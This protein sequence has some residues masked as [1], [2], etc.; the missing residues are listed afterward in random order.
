MR[1]KMSINGKLVGGV[2]TIGIED[3]ASGTVFEQCPIADEA[4]LDRA[5]A[6]AKA[7]FPAWASRTYADRGVS[8]NQFA[9]ALEENAGKM[10]TLLTREQGKPLAKAH[11]EIAW[12]IALL[13]F[14]ATQ[15]LPH[16]TVRDNETG[17]IV[18]TRTPLGVVAAITPSNYPVLMLVMKVAPALLSGNTVVAKPAPTTPLTTLLLGE[19]VLPVFPAGVLNV[20]TIKNDLATRLTCHPDVAKVSFT[21]ST[22][23]G[24]EVLQSASSTLKRVTLELG[25]NDAAIVLDDV[26]VDEVAPKI[27]MA[28]MAN[29]GQL[30]L[31][32]KRIYAPR[33]ISDRLCDALATLAKQALIDNGMGPSSQFVPIQNRAQYERVKELIEDSQDQGNIIASGT[34]ADG[35]GYFI[36]P[37]IVRDVSDDARLVREERF[38]PTMPVLVYDGIDELIERVNN[39]GYGPGGTIWTKDTKRAFEIAQR[40]Q[41]AT[42]WINCHVNFSFDVP[43]GG[44]GQSGM[45]VQLGQEGLEEFTQLKVISAVR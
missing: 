3:R 39:S 31:A 42:T 2:S 15:D 33:S 21:G 43:P 11:D 22:R 45:G 7:A 20:I 40:V 38:G 23:T 37:T 4:Q 6:A 35:S 36:P 18:E 12:S 16:K 1:Y 32:A 9:D 17:F 24:I 30:C 41:T 44:A 10:A 19:L 13:R 26:D 25:C 27:F 28:T 5:V 29:S 34:P 8:L 14:S